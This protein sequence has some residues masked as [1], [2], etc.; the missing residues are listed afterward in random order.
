MNSNLTNYRFVV[1]EI[2]IKE[3]IQ[4]LIVTNRIIAIG[5]Q[6]KQTGITIPHPLTDFIRIKYA[7]MGKSLN[8]QTIPAYIV[9]RFL[10]F[11]YY[12][13]K[14]GNNFSYHFKVKGLGASPLVMEVNIFHT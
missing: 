1:K 13:I 8:S 3:T 11:I 14:E 6:D 9:C 7:Y 10:N 4:D 5:I 2:P 12:K